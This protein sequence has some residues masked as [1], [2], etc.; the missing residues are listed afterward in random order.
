MPPI[1][2]M[3]AKT[4]TMEKALAMLPYAQIEPKWDALRGAIFALHPA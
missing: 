1:R 2:P 4:T 3:L